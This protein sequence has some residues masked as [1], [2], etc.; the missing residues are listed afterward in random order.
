MRGL[1][2]AVAALTMA[3][4][5]QQPAEPP[6]ALEWTPLPDGSQFTVGSI[7][8]PSDQFFDGPSAVMR[9][10]PDSGGYDCLVST[11]AS[12]QFMEF[13][14]TKTAELPTQHR[15]DFEAPVGYY[16][17]VSTHGGWQESVHSTAGEIKLNV[18]SFIERPRPN[19]W[20]K[21]EVEK[22]FRDNGIQPESHW[23]NCK[24]LSDV[25]GETSLAA[26]ASTEVTRPLIDGPG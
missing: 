17:V 22:L 3:A 10:W 21:G 26:V 9:C 13:V 6:K 8:V 1:L 18:V 12:Y 16:C 19:G 11:R 14:R 20:P 4:C 2:M 7:P 24:N 15:S 5:S 23:M 25:V